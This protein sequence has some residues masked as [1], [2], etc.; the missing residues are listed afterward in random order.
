MTHIA[1]PEAYHTTG[2]SHTVVYYS[3]LNLIDVYSIFPDEVVIPKDCSNSIWR[4]PGINE[5]NAEH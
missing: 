3:T 5:W 1:H 4:I 2:E